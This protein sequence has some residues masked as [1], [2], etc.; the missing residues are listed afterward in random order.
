M[1]KLYGIKA[2]DIFNTMEARFNAEAS[3]GLKCV[4]GYDI[5]GKGKWKIKVDNGTVKIRKNDNFSDCS[6][7]IKADPDTLAGINI[8]KIDAKEAL[9]SGQISVKG[10]A[11]IL[12]LSMK[13]FK[14]YIPAEAQK[15]KEEKLIVL[16][17]TIS[18]NQKF[19]TG[20]IMGQF[21]NGLKEKKILANKCPVCGRVQVPPREVCAV[22]RVRTE[23]MIE[24]GPKGNLR[25]LEY[26]HYSSPD[27]LT[28]EARE[29]PY[30]MI[31]VLL[32]GCKGNE[33]FTHYLRRDQ[34]NKVQAG[35]GERKGSILRPVW[36]ETRTGSVTDIKYFEI[37]EG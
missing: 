2:E 22:C 36:N 25:M 12:T 3:R 27:P 24:V 11:G 19:A 10:D 34:I 16:K 14:K 37:D 20:P 29:A 5:K 4:F 28:G 13:L 23:D 17:K 15:P 35:W 31:Y 21:L 8:G 1:S 33:T 18:V 9:N 26:V 30:G 7:I 6:S 32:D